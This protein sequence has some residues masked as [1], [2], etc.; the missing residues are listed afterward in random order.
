MSASEIEHFT[1][2][3]LAEKYP[4]VREALERSG[5]GLDI[6]DS[7][8]RV[9]VDREYAEIFNAKVNA[10]VAPFM[11]ALKQRG[12]TV[13]QISGMPSV[14]GIFP[15][16][17]IFEISNRNDISM[18]YLLDNTILPSLD[19]AVQNSQ[20]PS[21][22]AQGYSGE[23]VTIGI[24][25]AQNVDPK[26]IYIHQS[27]T[28]REGISDEP[29][30]HATLVAYCAVSN[31]PAYRGMAYSATIMSA[32][33]NGSSEDLV[34]ALVWIFDQNVYVVNHSEIQGPVGDTVE[35][36]DRAFDYWIRFRYRMV[37]QGAGNS[38]N[39]I[40]SP[41]KGWNLLTVGAYNDQNNLLWHDDTMADFSSYV[42][43]TSEHGDRE[44]PEVVA[45]GVNLTLALDPNMPPE[46]SGGTSLASPQTAGLAAL[47]LNRNLFLPAWPE[48]S[49]AIIMASA[50]HN[51]E[52]PL[53][54]ETDIGDLKDGAGAIN[55]YLGDKIA[56][57]RGFSDESCDSSCWWVDTISNSSLPTQSEKNYYFTV[58]ERSLVRI[59]VAWTSNADNSTNNY[60]MDRL[61]TDL[62]MVVRRTSPNFSLVGSSRSFDNS[63]EMVSFIAEEPGEYEIGIYKRRG[64]EEYNTIGVALLI[65][66]LPFRSYAP[67]IMGRE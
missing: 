16:H 53:V 7:T 43:P 51:I 22:W 2:E 1:W 35:F 50:T 60:A 17:F 4:E 45:P 32:G 57:R 12:Y 65:V 52:G 67:L 42:N 18:I 5:R 31:H 40:G 30:S 10:R 33:H 61:D 58:N 38:G 56:Q 13:E 11:E 64:D 24:L 36:M 44:K 3:I 46:P 21:V 47:L 37:T 55:A 49:R 34:E 59:A 48:A 9:Q 29:S 41:G 54:I 8:L 15:K 28:R 63:Y 66:E 27:S 23:G 39:S 26:N 6:E 25:E 19:I 62:D 14:I 20:A